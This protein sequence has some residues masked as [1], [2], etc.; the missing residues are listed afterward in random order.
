MTYTRI[1]NAIQ[2]G[3]ISATDVTTTEKT[4]HVTFPRAFANTPTVVLGLEV[5]SFNRRP[6]Y[7]ANVS[8]T[9]FDAVF[10]LSSGSGA[11]SC[12]ASWIAVA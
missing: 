11:A 3:S 6:V 8:A 1:N 7:A 9:G 12:W 10:A 2:R 4:V 5:A